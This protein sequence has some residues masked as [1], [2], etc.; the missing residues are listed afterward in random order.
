MDQ[1]KLTQDQKKELFTLIAPRSELIDPL[2]GKSDFNFGGEWKRRKKEEKSFY[3]RSKFRMELFELFVEFF[4]QDGPILLKSMMEDI[5]KSIIVRVLS[6]AQGNQR[7][8]AKVLG[9]KYT[10]LNEKVKRYN[11]RFQKSP[12]AYRSRLI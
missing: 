2:F 12:V 7:K 3:A 9:I 6:K 10:T 4:C 1:E 11:I 5:E 8:A